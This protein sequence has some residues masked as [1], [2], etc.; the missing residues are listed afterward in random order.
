MFSIFYRYIYILCEMTAL[1]ATQNN[2]KD[3]IVLS[4]L[5]YICI[6]CEMTALMA[7]QNNVKDPIVLNLLQVYL[8]SV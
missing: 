2:V 6:L 7:A 5:R 4:L 1:M 3:P 8:Y